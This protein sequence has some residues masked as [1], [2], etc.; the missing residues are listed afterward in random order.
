MGCPFP[1]W[2]HD[3]WKVRIRSSDFLFF[4]NKNILCIAMSSSYQGTKQRIVTLYFLSNQF[5][6][7][8]GG[9]LSLI[10]QYLQQWE[11]DSNSGSPNKDQQV[12]SSSYNALETSSL[13]QAAV[14]LYNF[15]HYRHY[16]VLFFFLNL[17]SR[18]FD[19]TKALSRASNVHYETNTINQIL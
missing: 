16:L 12:M 3:R 6:H 9:S 14:K 10:I 19:N 7:L 11:E 15:L 1:K 5:K 4:N 13:N 17:S 18:K 2:M 8:V